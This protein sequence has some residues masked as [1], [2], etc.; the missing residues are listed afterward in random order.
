M[1]RAALS[2]RSPPR[3]A[4]G[5][6]PLLTSHLSPLR[7]APAAALTAA[8][9]AAAAA[10]VTSG[11]YRLHYN[12]RATLLRRSPSPT[13]LSSGHL[14]LADLQSTSGHPLILPLAPGRSCRK[15]FRAHM[16]SSAAAAAADMAGGDGAAAVRQAVGAPP[17]QVI[18]QWWGATSTQQWTPPERILYSSLSLPHPASTSLRPCARPPSPLPTFPGGAP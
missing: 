14:R 12:T 18:V 5:T 8:A 10:A 9:A 2:T 3:P 6:H 7:T 17:L 11:G 16:D 1:Q 15:A 4:T 13:A